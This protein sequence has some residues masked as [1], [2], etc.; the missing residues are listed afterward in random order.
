M[1]PSETR[2]AELPQ[3]LNLCICYRP[4]RWQLEWEAE[5]GAEWELGWEPG[6]WAGW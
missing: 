2:S 1:A 6:W 5:G 3:E 4:Q